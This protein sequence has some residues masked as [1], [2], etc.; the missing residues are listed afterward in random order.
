METYLLGVDSGSTA[1]KAVIFDTAG[2]ALATGS[3]R[4]EQ[5]QPHARHVERDMQDTW[6]AAC[7]A[8]RDA[9]AQMPDVAIAAVGVTGHGDGLY[10]ADAAGAPLGP[11]I[12]SLDSRAFGVREQW[13]EA[14]VL[15]AALTLTGQQPYPYAAVSLLKWI[16]LNEPERF[17][18]IGHALFCKDWLR[19]CLTGVPATDPTE[20]SSSF[21]EVRS[22]TYHDDV[23]A[24]YGLEAIRGALPEIVPS[25]AQ[26]G[27]VSA[28]AAAQTGLAEGTP[29]AC[30]LHDVTSSAVGMGNTE[31]GVLSITAGTFSINEI[32]SAQPRTDARWACRNGTRPGQWMNMS[33]SPASSSN[34]DWATRELFRHE[35]QEAMRRGCSL[36]DLIGD[37]VE[38]AFNEPSSVMFH[39][40]LFGSPFEEPASA[41][42]FG[43]RSWHCRAHLARAVLEGMVFN[44][45]WHVEALTSAFPAARAGLTGGGSSSPLLAQLFADALG[46]AVDIPESQE[47]S[48]LGAA[49]C[50]GVSVGVYASLDDAA[51]RACRVQRTHAPDPQRHARLDDAYRLWTQLAEAVQPLWASLDRSASAH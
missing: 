12:L 2:R 19:L 44:H 17:A 31:P 14:G 3:R 25:A 27:R 8:I 39:P 10:L 38:A 18:R 40:F 30:G 24:L 5:R 28:L 35:A 37:E 34:V 46:V 41:S 36:F 26:A 42:F 23:L 49:L 1:T 22:Q 7:G 21:T 47:A 33:I 50:A 9:L 16:Q 51:A 15:D 48:A 29:V 32:L 43:V 45:R 6:L 4:V 20:A 11:G 13:R